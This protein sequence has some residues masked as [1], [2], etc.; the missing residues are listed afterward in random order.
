M[1]GLGSKNPPIDKIETLIG[2]NSTFQGRLVCDGNIRIDGVCEEGVIE[3]VGNIV[4]G[5]QAK[6]AAHLIAENVSVS[7]VVTGNITAS[8]RL[9]VI[10]SGQVW[11]DAHVSSIYVDDEADFHG[12]LIKGDKQEPPAFGLAQTGAPASDPPPAGEPEVSPESEQ[13]ETLPS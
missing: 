6:V 8:G 2:A 1:L 4:V 7:G 12:K 3:T 5:V 9:E 13:T 10:G 11:G